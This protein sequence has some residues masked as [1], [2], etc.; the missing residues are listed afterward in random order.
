MLEMILLDDIADHNILLRNML[1]ETLEA[2]GVHTEYREARTAEEEAVF[3]RQ[4]KDRAVCFLDIELGGEEN[5]I[6]AAYRIHEADPDGCIVYV[7]AYQQYAMDC[8][9][10]QK[11]PRFSGARRKN[12]YALPRAC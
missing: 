1:E 5:G 8:L 9:H 7:S 2:L 11:A 10:I 12:R 4:A 3:A 6:D